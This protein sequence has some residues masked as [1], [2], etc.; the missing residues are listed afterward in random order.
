MTSVKNKATQTE[1]KADIVIIQLAK[2][3]HR[4]Q[5]RANVLETVKRWITQEEE[6]EER[7]RRQLEEYYAEIE[8]RKQARLKR[9]W[10][11]IDDTLFKKPK[12]PEK[13]GG[14]QPKTK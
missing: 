11:K 1:P 4:P 7:E 3:K 5:Q 12:V 14:K 13:D 9:N 8:K 2:S 10:K 6:K